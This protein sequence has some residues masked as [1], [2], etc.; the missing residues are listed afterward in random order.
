MLRGGRL[1]NETITKNKDKF[2]EGKVLNI[3]IYNRTVNDTVSQTLTLPNH[4]TQRLFDGYRIRKLTP[5]E[6]WR[7]MGFSDTDFD[8]AKSTGN[9][10]TQLYK[11]A[12]NSIVVDV[13]MVILNNLL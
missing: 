4:N 3:D 1:L 6:C 12:G 8:K 9:S 2:K 13:L 5:K 7:L 11:Q 10:D